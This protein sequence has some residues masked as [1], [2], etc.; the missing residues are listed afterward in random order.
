MWEDVIGESFSRVVVTRQVV[1]VLIGGK[2]IA[3]RIRMRSFDGIGNKIGG[4]VVVVGGHGENRG[5]YIVNGL[6][7]LS[8]VK[9]KC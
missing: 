7:N 9:R 2:K 8:E 4:V 5:R 3:S 6:H 1:V